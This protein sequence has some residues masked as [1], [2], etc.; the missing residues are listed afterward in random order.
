VVVKWPL[1]YV[2][3]VFALETSSA[4]HPTIAVPAQ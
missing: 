3:A 4:P 2:E 1:H